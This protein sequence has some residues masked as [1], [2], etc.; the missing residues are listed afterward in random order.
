MRKQVH[1]PFWLDEDAIW[2][3]PPHLADDEGLLGVGGDLSPQ[4]LLLA[5]ANGIFP[6]YS[7][8]N[9]ILWWSPDPRFVLYPGELHVG[10]STRQRVRNAGYRFSLDTAFRQVISACSSFPRPNQDGTWITDE[11]LEAY[12][13]LHELGYAHSAESWW[14]EEL[15]GGVY[16]VALGSNFFGE[17][18]FSFRADASKVAFVRLVEQL[19]GW[20]FTL[21]DCQMETDHLRRFGAH[22]VPR[23]RFLLELAEG[24]KAETRRGKWVIS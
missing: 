7:H 3:P 21:V 19:T 23:K 8:E 1:G 11:M 18:M 17:S 22:D 12:C 14:G 9:P 4:R 24:L 13:A 20:G 15:V 6:W 5:Y 10:R 2:F 16:G